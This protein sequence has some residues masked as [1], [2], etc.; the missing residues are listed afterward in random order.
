LLITYHSQITCHLRKPSK[1]WMHCI[2]WW[3]PQSQNDL[4]YNHSYKGKGSVERKRNQILTK[5]SRSTRVLHLLTAA[6]RTT[7]PSSKKQRA[8]QKKLEK[9][10]KEKERREQDTRETCLHGSIQDEALFLV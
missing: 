7:M 9:Q 1:Y 10:Q 8:K 2:A 5:Q 6:R 4:H 3:L